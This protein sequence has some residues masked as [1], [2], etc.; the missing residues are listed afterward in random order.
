[1]ESWIEQDG[2]TILKGNIEFIEGEVDKNKQ[3]TC[4]IL[5][6]SEDGQEHKIFLR[7]SSVQE[8]KEFLNSLEQVLRH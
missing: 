3:P 8:Y 2:K 5:V 1:M 4:F 6:T 7:A